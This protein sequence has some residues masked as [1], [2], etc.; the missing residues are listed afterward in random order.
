MNLRTIISK[1]KGLKMIW[2][3]ERNGRR[4]YLAGTAHFF[5]YS[6]K[7]SL[8][9]YI[10]SMD[11]VLL[12][13][14]LDER[15]MNKVVDWGVEQER[16]SL[17]YEALDKE[18]IARINKKLASPLSNQS[19]LSSFI[20]VF[21][22]QSNDLLYSLTIGLKPWMAFFAVWVNY[23]HGRDWK[24]SVD[25]EAYTVAQELGKNIYFLETIDE[26]IEVLSSIPFERIIHFL[27]KIEDWGKYTNAYVKCYL[28]GDLDALMSIPSEF[29]SRCTTVIDNRDPILYERMRVFFERGNAIAFVGAPHVKEIKKMLLGDG[30]EVA[31][32]S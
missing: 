8:V 4:S 6:F 1:E 27:K 25:L 26:Q 7:K 10:S 9:K 31:Q 15:N 30:Y 24:Y 28:K 23:L 22:P 12:E 5:P 32:L 21:K 16:V 14:P 11:T 13:G 2:K 3:I 18:T 29:P 19:S 20:D 17:L